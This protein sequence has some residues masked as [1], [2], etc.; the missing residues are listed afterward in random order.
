[1]TVR[2][3]VTVRVLANNDVGRTKMANDHWVTGEDWITDR[4]DQPAW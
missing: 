1:M 2:M 3:L 4:D